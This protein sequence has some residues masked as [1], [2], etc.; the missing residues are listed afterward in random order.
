MLL[1]LCRAGLNSWYHINICT[2]D[3]YTI[4]QNYSVHLFTDNHNIVILLFEQN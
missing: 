4:E 2:W 1:N 3:K